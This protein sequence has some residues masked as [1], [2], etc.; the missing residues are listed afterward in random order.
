[1][2]QTVAEAIIRAARPDRVTVV[3]IDGVDGAGKTTF[4]D[5]LV[6]F[7]RGGGRE[8]IRATVDGFHQPKVKRYRLGRNSPDGFYRDSYDYAAL[9]AMLLDPL[10]SGSR[11]YKRAIFDVDRD[12]PVDGN[13]EET[14]LE[15]VLLFDGIFL[16]RPELREYWD[17]S[18]FLDV[19]WEKN[20]HLPHQPA[21]TLGLP[22]PSSVNHRYAEGQRIY[23]RESDPKAAASVVI[24]NTNLAAPSIV[25]LSS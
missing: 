5:E 23:F 16:H 8:V 17:F 7:I 3:G 9:K 2:L 1:M 15:S 20:H 10:R 14:D 12:E 24:D 4:A 22:E 21:W 25:R 6:P 11:T 19:P 18:I 13:E